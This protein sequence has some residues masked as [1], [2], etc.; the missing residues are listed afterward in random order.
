[1]EFGTDNAIFEEESN[2]IDIKY[3][4][5]TLKYELFSGFYIVFFPRITLDSGFGILPWWVAATFFIF[6]L[7][8]FR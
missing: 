5:N 2:F 6:P 7:F 8:I 4:C 3:M 1:M